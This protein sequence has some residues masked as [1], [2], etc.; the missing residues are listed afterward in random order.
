[1]YISIVNIWIYIKESIFHKKIKIM[2]SFKYISIKV[3]ISWMF[4]N[5]FLCS[6][7]IIKVVIYKILLDI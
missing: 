2:V 7:L 5:R 6:E 4:I 1:M 3:D